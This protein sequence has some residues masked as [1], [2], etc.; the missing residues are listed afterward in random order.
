MPAEKQH[1]AV[2]S[3]EGQDTTAAAPVIPPPKP[4]SEVEQSATCVLEM[5]IRSLKYPWMHPPSR[6]L[7][8]RRTST[9]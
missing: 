9:S 5:V 4:L 2:E 1:L 3:G 6:K 8:E 7:Q